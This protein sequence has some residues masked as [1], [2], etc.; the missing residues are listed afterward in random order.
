[1]GRKGRSG[2]VAWEVAVDYRLT[3]PMEFPF[4][5]KSQNANVKIIPDIH[6]RRASLGLRVDNTVD[7]V[8]SCLPLA[9][10]LLPTQNS[11]HSKAL[12]NQK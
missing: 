7:G 1:M 11:R 10:H 2:I 8:R 4:G 6:A 9:Q 5:C 12:D 3:S